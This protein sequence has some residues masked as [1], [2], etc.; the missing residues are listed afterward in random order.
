MSHGA[1]PVVMEEW[2]KGYD[3]SCTVSLRLQLTFDWPKL[4]QGEE[5]ALLPCA[6]KEGTGVVDG[7]PLISG[8][9]SEQT[10]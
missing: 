1:W 6:W 5:S 3:E 10:P 8:R 7:Y 4:S 2:E 9:T